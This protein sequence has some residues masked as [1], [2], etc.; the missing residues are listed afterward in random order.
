MNLVTDYLN[1]GD[2]SVVDCLYLGALSVIDILDLGEWLVIDILGVVGCYVWSEEYYKYLVFF[3]M[4]IR[5]TPFAM[6]MHRSS[7]STNMC[8]LSY[9]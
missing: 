2:W 4:N 6:F 8:H 7:P 3:I 1:G 9:Y 5:V